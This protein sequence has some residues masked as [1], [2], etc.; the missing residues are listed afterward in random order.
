MFLL[1]EGRI[2]GRETLPEGWIA[3]ASTPQRIG[4]E[5]VEYG[6][7]LWPL[8]GGAYAAIGIFGQFVV[9]FPEQDMVVAMWGAQSKPEGSATVDEYDFFQ[10]LAQALP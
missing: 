4:G 8:A 1:H 7:M 5:W 10:A 2:E 3:T 6:Y 9:V